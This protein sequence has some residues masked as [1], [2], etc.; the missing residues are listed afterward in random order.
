MTADTIDTHKY[1][2]IDSAI[3]ARLVLNCAQFCQ[4]WTADRRIECDRLARETGRDSYRI[5][6]ARLQAL[7]KQG[8]IKFLP[9]TGWELT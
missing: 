3:L 1:A 2:R 8:R 7:R 4:L 6:D 9:A 5:L